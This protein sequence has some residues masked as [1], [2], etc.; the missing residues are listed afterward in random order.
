[1]FQPIVENFPAIDEDPCSNDSEARAGADAAQVE[2]LCVLQ[3]LPV[4]ALPVYNYVNQQ[5]AGGLAGGNPDLSEETADSFSFGVVFDSPFEGAFSNLQASIDFYQIEIE[6][7]IAVI[8]ATTFVSR[9]Y[10]REFN[11]NFEL[12]NSFC[13]LFRRDPVTSEI[14]DAAELNDNLAKFKT[15]GIDIQLDWGIDIGSGALGISWI[16]THLTKWDRKA[17]PDDVGFVDLAGTIGN[18]SISSV[19]VARPDWKWSFNSDYVIGNLGLN[20]RWRYVDS[21][22]D[23]TVP[24]FDTSEVHYFDV[25]ASY[26][27]TDLF[28]GTLSG[29]SARLGV[30]NLTDE[31]PEIIPHRVQANT[32]P[33]TYDTLGRRYFVNV[34]YSFD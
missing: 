29:L 8:D 3:G 11:P 9:C 19:G 10:D 4:A 30:T 20:L 25:G 32:D 13:N 33:S 18:R 26:A 28:G 34:T 27:F 1:L 21:M 5:V 24:E 16:A 15:A 2:G 17:L 31:D 12:D 6:D 14:I 23:D 22:T 7:A